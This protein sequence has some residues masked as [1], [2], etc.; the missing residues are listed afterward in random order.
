[1]NPLFSTITKRLG[2]G[3]LTLFPVSVI[4]LSVINMLPVDFGKAALGQAATGE[5]VAPFRRELDMARSKGETPR[6]INLR[7]ALP[8]AGAPIATVI[9][10]NLA[11]PVA[12]LVWWRPSTRSGWTS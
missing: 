7:H 6:Q 3:L 1:M 8:N 5:T 12:G 4:I 11:H 9:A 10:F 2:L